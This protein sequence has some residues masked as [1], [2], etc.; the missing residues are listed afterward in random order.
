[1][2]II[3]IMVLL[4]NLLMA[5]AGIYRTEKIK[6]K[7]DN[8]IGVIYYNDIGEI[9][10][11]I[12]YEDT[13]GKEIKKAKIYEVLDKERYIGY[14]E[15]YYNKGEKF[16]S[17][18]KDKNDNIVSVSWFYKKNNENLEEVRDGKNNLIRYYSHTEN[19]YEDVTKRVIKEKSLDKLVTIEQDMIK[20][21]L[22]LDTLADILTDDEDLVLF[23]TLKRIDMTYADRTEI[24]GAQ[25]VTDSIKDYTGV[26]GVIMPADVFKG[27]IE[28]GQVTYKDLKGLI[29]DEELYMM[30]VSGE[31]LIG[32]VERFLTLPPRHRDF[33]HTA[34][35]TFERDD[36]GDLALVKVEGS[37]VDPTREY[38]LVVPAYVKDG[39]GIYYDFADEKTYKI[40]YKTSIILA[41]Y[42]KELNM[43][44]NSYKLEK[45]HK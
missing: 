14:V 11:K 2:R 3:M 23:Q 39:N 42:V 22:P 28:I 31:K 16:L 10:K 38:T 26:Q 7:K 18:E 5:Q 43:L 30:T 9:I 19:G 36:E 6:D 13:S 8:E 1:M 27:S 35:L 12:V 40:P 37:I 32:L 15:Y 34:G 17:I 25:L 24:L 4:S 41:N 21:L 44:D 20:V 29:K 33:M 45:R